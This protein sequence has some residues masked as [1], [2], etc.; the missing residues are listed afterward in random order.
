[1]IKWTTPTLKCTIPNNV[2]FDY[3]VLT[4]E[5][6]NTKLEKTITSSE[7]IDG[8][9]NVTF[10]QEETGMFERYNVVNVQLNLVDGEQRLATNIV[11]LQVTRNLHNEVI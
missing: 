6:G 1:M 4:L 9:F 11:Q 5:Q 7:V 10:T 2:G 8:V 3:I